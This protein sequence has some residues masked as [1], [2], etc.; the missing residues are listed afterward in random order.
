M[1]ILSDIFAIVLFII[2]IIFLCA[3]IYLRTTWNIH[4][5]T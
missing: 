4:L 3:K 5:G 1:L 2:Q